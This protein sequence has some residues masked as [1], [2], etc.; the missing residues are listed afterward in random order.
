[1]VT[2]FGVAPDRIGLYSGLGEG[3][4]MLVE[5]IVATTWARLSDK[6]GRRPCMLYGC[7]VCFVAAGMTGFSRGV[8]QL[9]F[10]RAAFGLN[11]AGVIVKILA[12]EVSHPSNRSRIFSIFSPAFAGGAMLGTFIGGE[13]AHPYGRMPWWL[14]GT[15]EIW[16]EW[17]YALP[18]LISGI[19]GVFVL[20]VSF[21]YLA[22]TRP[23]AAERHESEHNEDVQAEKRTEG[24]MMAATLR[25]PN[26]VLLVTV[27]CFFQI[28]TVIRSQGS[29]LVKLMPV[30]ANFSWDGLFTV[31]TYTDVSLGG[32]GLPVD[33]IGL[34]FT[35]SSLFYVCSTP[36]VLPYLQ[37]RFGSIRTLSL[38]FACWPV[39]ALMIPLAQKAADGAR[40]IMWLVL[41]V[42]IGLKSFATCAWPMSD[43]MI[44]G[45]FDDYPDLLATG[46]A[47]S[48]IAGAGGRAIGP[49]VS[50]WIFSISTLYP[51]GSLG[52]QMSWIYFLVMAL[53][54]LAMTQLLP[55]D[56][57]GPGKG[58]YEAVP[59]V[60]GEED[61][62]VDGE[63]EE[64]T[65]G[66]SRRVRFAEDA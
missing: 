29:V 16:R 52:R 59:M 3:A 10:W 19:F 33:V 34:I 28:G 62:E 47:I 26:F 14:G 39:I 2:S 48:L 65:V 43:M 49:A 35:F 38:I 37:A 1:M 57:A 45:A 66:V 46:S 54:P 42:Q 51:T 31:Y 27:F 63:V 32:L 12:S 11:P 36:F 21:F 4:L 53:L 41:T 20:F 56:E 9:V 17:P 30:S 7:A 50:G 13:F 60:E 25:V 22:E 23:P 18:C 5:A 40:P 15:A 24:R 61:G 6:Y 8:W 55:K 44:M 64:D 58:D